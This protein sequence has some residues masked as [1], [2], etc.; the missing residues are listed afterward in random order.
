[1]YIKFAQMSFKSKILTSL[2]THFPD[3]QQEHAFLGFM[4]I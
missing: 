1:M 2:I 3:A 4:P